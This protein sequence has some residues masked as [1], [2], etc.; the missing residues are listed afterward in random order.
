MARGKFLI[1]AID[2]AVTIHFGADDQRNASEVLSFD[3]HDDLS[4]IGRSGC[5]YVSGRLDI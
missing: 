4:D 1:F 5:V 2:A 3:M